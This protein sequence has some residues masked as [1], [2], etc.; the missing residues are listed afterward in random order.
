MKNLL[1][2][3]LIACSAAAYADNG[4][5]AGIG[6]GYGNINTSTS[7]GFKFADGSSNQNNGNMLGSVYLGYDFN[8][9][10]GVQAGYSYI[11]STQYTTEVS[12]QSGAQGSFN[13]SQQIIDWGVIGHLPFSIMATSLSGLS[14]FGKLSMGYSMVSFDGGSVTTGSS[15]QNI[16]GSSQSIVPVLGAG[17]EYGIDSVGV[18]LEYN[19]VGNNTVNSNS[20]NL[21]NVNNNLYLISALYHF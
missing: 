3:C 19:Y 11:A 7:N 9:F 1:L 18:R 8:H 20:Q 5:Y 12:S 13:A 16:P 6:A 4:L 17:I 10:F 2:A 14:I 15:T 21:M